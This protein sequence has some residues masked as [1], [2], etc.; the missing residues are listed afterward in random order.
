MRLGKSGGWRRCSGALLIGV[1]GVGLAAATAGDAFG[2]TAH[3]RGAGDLPGTAELRRSAAGVRRE[4][5]PAARVVD[6][7]IERE[8]VRLAKIYRLFVE[9]GSRHGVDPRL[10]YSICRQES[11]FRSRAKSPAGALGLMQFM[12][13]TARRFGINPYDDEQAVDGAARYLRYLLDMFQG[14]VA[15]AVASYNAGEFAVRAWSEGFS[16]RNSR[17]QLINGGRVRTANGLPPYRETVNYVREVSAT[18]RETD[19]GAVFGAEVA[20]RL[21]ATRYVVKGAARRADTARGESVHA[22][23][24][25]ESAYA[26]RA[27]GGRGERASR[28]YAALG[29]GETAEHESAPAA[30]AGGASDMSRTGARGDGRVG[31]GDSFFVDS[32][33]GQR[34]VEQTRASSAATVRPAVS[35]TSVYVGME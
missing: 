25:V 20:A 10:L 24:R 22:T 6:G 1:V 17:G 4:R 7:A 33:S 3:L 12:P 29:D 21:D 14:D 9:A 34:F 32:F 13:A 35:R 8:R 5:V 16:F 11:R 15:K 19:W 31:R 30:G 27:D 23:G 26:V 18:W 2:Q 28:F